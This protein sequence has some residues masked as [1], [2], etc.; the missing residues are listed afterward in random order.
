VR[1]H[2]DV[3]AWLRRV[4]LGLPLALG[5]AMLFKRGHHTA[6]FVLALLGGPAIEV[7]ARLFESH[8]RKLAEN[9]PMTQAR[10][11]SGSVSR[12]G[13]GHY[14]CHRAELAYSYSVNNEFWPGFHA[15]DFDR[16]SEAWNFVNALKGKTVLVNYSPGKNE[17]SALTDSAL[18]A[19]IPDPSVLRGRRWLGILLAGWFPGGRR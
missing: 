5:A 1:G 6:F 12:I 16:E 3:A 8:R 4:V 13:N 9:W 7:V 15:R 19:A 11:E 10:V 2:V 18:R 17:V 14:A